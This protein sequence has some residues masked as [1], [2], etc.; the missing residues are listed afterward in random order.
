MLLRLL[1]NGRTWVKLSAPYETSKLGPPLYRRCRRARQGAG[2]GGARALRLGEQLAASLGA[3]RRAARRRRPPRPAARLGARRG[4][5]A[6]DPRRQP[7]QAL[8]ILMP[9]GAATHRA[10]RARHGG[11]AACQEPCRPRRIASRSPMRSARARRGGENSPSASDFR[12][13][14]ISTRSSPTRA[15]SAV[16]IL[17]PPNTHLD[18]VRRCAAAG[19]HILLE[20]PLEIT[21][22]ARARA[23]RGVPR[24]RA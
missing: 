5:A 7:R 17:T 10:H 22:D 14:T 21:T 8:R 4:G 18:L 20:K 16:A 6:Q 1:E 9:H 12:W 3:A 11:D 13:P 23:G 19:K 2:Q 24:G 15:S